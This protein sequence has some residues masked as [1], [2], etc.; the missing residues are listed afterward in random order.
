[1]VVPRDVENRARIIKESMA[2][3]EKTANLDTMMSRMDVAADNLRALLKYERSGIPTITPSP[4]HLL[5]ELERN[6]GQIILKWAED[7]AAVALTKAAAALSQKTAMSTAEKALVK[8]REIHHKTSDPAKMDALEGRLE[9]FIHDKQ[10][11]VHLE[12]ARKAEF[13][14]Q[15]KKAIDAYQEAVYLLRTDRIDDGKQTQQIAEIEEK[16]KKLGIQGS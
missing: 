7:S 4:S 13:K 15:P 10:L 11:E 8:L 16:I 3:V 5:G 2:L 12:A 14:G 9:G 1:M 6:R